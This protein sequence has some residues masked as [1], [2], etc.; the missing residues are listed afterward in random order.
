MNIK[1]LLK[2]SVVLSSLIIGNAYANFVGLAMCRQTHIKVIN[3][4]G[5]DLN[6][7][8][9][10][11]KFGSGVSLKPGAKIPSHSVV[12]VDA[13]VQSMQKNARVNIVESLYFKDSQSNKIVFSIYSPEQLKYGQPTFGISGDGLSL[14]KNSETYNPIQGPECMTYDRATVTL[15]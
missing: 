5:H 9:G 10:E 6:Y 4:S 8:Y 7:E 12:E 13:Q 15:T 1:N 2:F 14:V 11:F 3:N